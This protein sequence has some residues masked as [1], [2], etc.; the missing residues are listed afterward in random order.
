MQLRIASIG[1]LDGESVKKGAG[2]AAAWRGVMPP[3]DGGPGRG[4]V[5]RER[6]MT[7]RDRQSARR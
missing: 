2:G 1:T 7:D 3:A 5:L 6:N 4:C